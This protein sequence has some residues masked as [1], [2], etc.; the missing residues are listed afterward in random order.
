MHETVIGR[1]QYWKQYRVCLAIHHLL[2]TKAQSC[3]A[4]PS[5]KG[6]ALL[7]GSDKESAADGPSPNDGSQGS[8]PR[9]FATGVTSRGL[10]DLLDLSWKGL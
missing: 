6:L 1:M 5:V 2:Y 3:P 9:G 10:L 4:L 7:K 8:W